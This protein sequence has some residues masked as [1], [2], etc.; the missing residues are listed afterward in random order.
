MYQERITKI[1]ARVG[2]IIHRFEPANERPKNASKE[3]K[4]QTELEKLFPGHGQGVLPKPVDDVVQRQA[5]LHGVSPDL[6]RAVVKA[7]SNGNPRAVSNAGAVG[8]MQLMPGTAQSLGV[9][10]YDMEQ[11][12]DGGIRYLKEM[13]GRFGNLNDVLA[14]YNAGPGAVEKHG[15]VPPYPE[16]QEYVK[17]IRKTLREWHA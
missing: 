14:A 16:T 2:E 15:G 1:N 6:I 5:R 17:R 13:A 7:E 4:F 11:N 12:V 10:P 9:D 3:D 8:L